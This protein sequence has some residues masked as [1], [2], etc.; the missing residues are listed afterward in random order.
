[1][2]QF[3]LHRFGQLLKHHLLTSR[4]EIV[5]AFLWM[6]VSF[7]LLALFMTEVVYNGSDFEYKDQTEGY[8]GMSLFFVSVI[9]LVAASRIISNMK[10]KPSRIN[11]L[12]L[13]ATNAEKYVVRLLHV[14]VLMPLL[15][16]L[17]VAAADLARML[18]S[19][20]WG[21][22]FVLGMFSFLGNLH[23]E[24]SFTGETVLL[25]LLAVGMTL[26]HHAVYV[27]GGTLF[28]KH[29]FLLTCAVM[30]FLFI[31][32]SRGIIGLVSF[33]TDNIDNIELS[34][35]TTMTLGY[36]A[37]TVLLAVDALIYWLSYKVFCRIQVINNKW[38]NL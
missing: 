2:K 26:F 30:F 12:M 1:M 28:R 31:V 29:P 10:D 34:K 14:S 4:G 21:R 8:V 7:F 16:L 15:A 27:L 19:L 3:D 38:L 25:L 22:P 20:L 5:R 18:V 9:V 24:I 6:T 37:A 32:L 36:V 23:P 33:I 13:P 35:T 17:A 11:Y